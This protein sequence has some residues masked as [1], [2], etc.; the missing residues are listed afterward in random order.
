MSAYPRRS[1]FTA[2][3]HFFET[4]KLLE[5]P[6]RKILGSK[7]FSSTPENKTMS[8]QKRTCPSISSASGCFYSCKHC[9]KKVK[10]KDMNRHLNWCGF[11]RGSSNLRKTIAHE[12]TKDVPACIQLSPEQDDFSTGNT[13]SSP[14]THTESTPM[15]DYFQP[16]SSKQFS[17]TA[18]TFLF[19]I[20]SPEYSY[21]FTVDEEAHVKIYSILEGMGA[22]QCAFDRIM[23]VIQ[24]EC[25]KGWDPKKQIFKR[26]KLLESLMKKIPSI[27]P[28]TV[29]LPLEN[30]TDFNLS[31]RRGHNDVASI[32]VFDFKEQLEDLL[33]DHLLFGDMENLQVNKE[34]PFGRYPS[35]LESGVLDDIHSGMWYKDTYH[36]CI[37]DP[38]E[39]FLAPIL[40][41]VDKTGTDKMNRYGL[42]PVIFTTSILKQSARNKSSSWRLLG[43]LPSFDEK[44]S[45]MKGTERGRTKSHGR[46]HRNYHLCLSVI[47][48]SLVETQKSR[49]MSHV[50]LGPHI[51]HC[52]IVTPVCFMI[53]DAKSQ[54]QICGRYGNC[55]SRRVCRACDCPKDQLGNPFHQCN[56]IASS[57]TDQWI[58][59][60]LST[61][62]YPTISAS[63]DNQR[64]KPEWKSADVTTA[65]DLLQEFSLYVCYNAFREVD[66]GDNDLGIFGATPTDLM[67]AFLEGIL[68]YALRLFVESL[69]PKQRA[70]IDTIV[71]DMMGN[72][73][74]SKKKDF[75]RVNFTHGITNL[76]FLTAEEWAGVALAYLLVCRSHRGRLVLYN[77]ASSTL[78]PP[79]GIAYDTDETESH[80]E[81]T[82]GSCSDQSQ[83]EYSASSDEE[84][85][86][87]TPLEP[88]D[89][90]QFIIL[91]EGMLSFHAFYKENEGLEW[92][93]STAETMDSKIRELLSHLAETIPRNC[94]EGWHLQKF[95]EITHVVRNMCQFGMPVNYD[96]GPC[97]NALIHF[98]KKPSKTAQKRGHSKFL[99]QTSLRLEEAAFMRTVHNKI[100]SAKPR[101]EHP[102]ESHH[103]VD[104]TE[105][106]PS[107]LI[108][109][110]SFHVGVGDT[111]KLS[112][113]EWLGKV[114]PQIHPIIMKGLEDYIRETGSSAEYIHGYTLYER[115]GNRIR[116]HP[117]FCSEGSWY[118]WVMVKY[119][120][121]GGEDFF[122][123]KVLSFFTVDGK[124][125][126]FALTH[127]V[128]VH[129]G[130]LDQSIL[131]QKYF[132]E[133]FKDS[134]KNQ[135]LPLLRVVSVDTFH[136][137]VFVVE[138]NP[139]LHE[140][141][142]YDGNPWGCP[143]SSAIL[144]KDRKCWSQQ[145]KRYPWF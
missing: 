91:L 51:R 125:E 128:H 111:G 114:N 59:T 17:K 27:S 113:Y 77:E 102:M 99:Q 70:A 85:A 142:E 66:L 143:L 89:T 121:E 57:D 33:N 136:E 93:F 34:N 74:S 72:L 35:F 138:E 4:Y 30:D 55:H 124:E 56:F 98:A 60:C 81:S 14:Y 69:T 50:R 9:Q 96:T 67:H 6:P 8:Q 39:Q 65:R 108:G 131:T 106:V 87:S 64:N 82:N 120:T 115:D 119:E 122:P 53:G 37:S 11:S 32:P 1:F 19:P 135:L 52:E 126:I 86:E 137:P 42:E 100:R 48:Q 7:Y 49:Y 38:E 63:E 79:K 45:A 83:I 134:K 36:K 76:T 141:L 123:S 21:N 68:K 26:Q 127:T 118:D 25:I 3:T 44:S 15:K 58:D 80:T 46:S 62:M 28:R 43:Y 71:D 116:A 139:G 75:P 112:Q 97:E 107:K 78:P 22:P 132:L 104:S 94:G 144:V 145:F 41:Y 130:Q 129:R 73:R 16:S 95:H 133:Y 5:I 47:L 29:H 103:D 10:L 12:N 54:D 18:S 31:Y 88:I 92:S 23:A 84:S 61:G 110:P 117:N 2:S 40:L 140:R 13:E 20:D 24:E 105:G 101:A 109:Y 90:H